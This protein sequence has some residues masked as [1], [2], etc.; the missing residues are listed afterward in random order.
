MSYV[1]K[2]VAVCVNLV[3]R[4]MERMERG[5]RQERKVI[6]YGRTGNVMK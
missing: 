1:Q 5:I 4:C 2:G 6:V 3:S